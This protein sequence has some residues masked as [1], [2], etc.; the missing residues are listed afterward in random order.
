MERNISADRL[1]R[2]RNYILT[3][4]QEYE[5]FAKSRDIVGAMFHFNSKA[6]WRKKL[7]AL[8]N[9]NLAKQY[10]KSTQMKKNLKPVKLDIE[11]EIEI[12]Q[13]EER[14]LIISTV[15]F[16]L[17]KFKLIINLQSD[18]GFTVIDRRRVEIFLQFKIL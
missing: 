8:T 3:F 9:F 11:I 15:S 2:N 13:L 17:I 5:R 7:D 12:N 16:T 14:K 1:L 6:E 18:T 4:S 10:H